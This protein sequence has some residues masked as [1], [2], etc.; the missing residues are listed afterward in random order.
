MFDTFQPKVD[1]SEY[2][3]STTEWKELYGEIEEELPPGMPEPL[4]KS[5][6]IIFC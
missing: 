1:D 2:A 3:S 5:E 4:G 6:H